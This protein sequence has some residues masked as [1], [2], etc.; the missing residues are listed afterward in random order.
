MKFLGMAHSVWP[1]MV[2]LAALHCATAGAF[3]QEEGEAYR[4]QPGD[5]LSIS[6]WREEDLTTEV[7]VRPDGRISIPLA[8]DISARDRSLEELRAEITERL[9]GYIPDL[10]V[11]VSARQLLGHKIYVIGKVAR[12]GEFVLNGRVD[13]MQALSMAGGATRFAGLENI[14]ILRR[15]DGVERVIPFNYALVEKGRGLEQNILLEVGDVVVV[16]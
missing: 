14:K 11:T 8:G 3:A 13:V 10:V 7:V 4:I 16:P 2:L 9:S 5:V 6:V 15:V 12:P 1:C